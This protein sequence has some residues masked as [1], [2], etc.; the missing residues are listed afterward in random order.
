LL[1]FR[2]PGIIQRGKEAP[3]LIKMD[4]RQ[5]QSIM[6]TPQSRFMGR[7]Y[8]VHVTDTKEDFEVIPQ[9]LTVSAVGYIPQAVTFSLY[10]PKKEPQP[11]LPERVQKMWYYGLGLV[12]DADGKKRPRSVREAELQQ[13]VDV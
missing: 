3:Y 5:I 7:R 9:L 13:P 10:N 8:I 6:D 1:R 12:R 11:K 4:P 2:I